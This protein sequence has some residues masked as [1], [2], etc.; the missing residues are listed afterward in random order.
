MNRNKLFFLLAVALVLALVFPLV[1]AAN[2]V[3]D[4]LATGVTNCGVFLDA[5]AKVTIPVTPV[6]SPVGNICKFDVST[7]SAG[8]HTIT[9][10]AIIV[11][12]VF[13]TKES[14]QSSPPLSF[15]V[16]G[17]PGAPVNLRLTP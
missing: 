8:T 7:V 13:G 5:N 6:T 2:V 11:D 10:T 1:H 4:P 15:S 12:P 16:P 14:P 9:M 3:T 17:T